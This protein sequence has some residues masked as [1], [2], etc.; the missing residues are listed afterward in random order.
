MNRRNI[1]AAL[2]VNMSFSDAR[3]DRDSVVLE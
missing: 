3:T 2:N 1:Y